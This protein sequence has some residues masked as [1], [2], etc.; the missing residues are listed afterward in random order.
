MN[1]G[2]IIFLVVGVSVL[3]PLGAR[4]AGNRR[5]A[6]RLDLLPRF[7]FGAICLALALHPDS[8]FSYTDEIGNVMGPAAQSTS[9]VIFGILGVYLFASAIRIIVKRDYDRPDADD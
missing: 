3:L 4:F 1:P 5:L 7:S 2:L 6:N 8:T 9:R